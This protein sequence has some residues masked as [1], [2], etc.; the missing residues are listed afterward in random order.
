MA[1]FFCRGSGHRRFLVR[2]VRDGVLRHVCEQLR[3]PPDMTDVNT[4]V[5]A[6]A[7]RDRQRAKHLE[8]T[9]SQVDTNLTR[10]DDYPRSSFLDAMQKLA[11]CV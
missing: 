1:E 5:A 2:E 10:G 4:I 9:L 11:G 3:L 7:R 8:K 6:L